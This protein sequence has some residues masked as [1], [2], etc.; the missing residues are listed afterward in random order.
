[1]KPK[2]YTILSVA[3]EEGIRAGYR[4]A[5]KHTDSPDEDVAIGNIH[6]EV[7]CS[8]V[9]YFTFEDSSR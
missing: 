2:L 5:H 6:S 3:I 8:L 9:D 7:M 1:M 4:R